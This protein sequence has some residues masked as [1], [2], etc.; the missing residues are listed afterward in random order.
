MLNALNLTYGVDEDRL[1]M[2]NNEAG[3]GNS[4]TGRRMLSTDNSPL[5]SP[6]QGNKANFY[7]QMAERNAWAM[8]WNELET[9]NDT[10]RIPIRLNLECFQKSTQL[11]T[12]RLA[13]GGVFF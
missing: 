3:L 10:R 13:S 11:S 6:K 12:S 8:T 9:G 5:A 4:V 2:G 7:D 1:H